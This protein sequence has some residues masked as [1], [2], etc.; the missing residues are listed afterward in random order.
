MKR[1]V[2]DYRKGNFN[3]LRSALEG[4]DLCEV[5]ES[6]VD[7]SHGWLKWKEI[8]L[9]AVHKKIPI[10]TIKNINSPPWIN[11]EII[12]AIK[13]KETVRRKLKSTPSDALLAKFKELRARVKQL[14][15]HYRAHFF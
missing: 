15:S 3:G 5:I 10:R 6:E 1:A 9:D 12:H 11:S 2:F 8:F 7:V 13:K 14:V 4:M